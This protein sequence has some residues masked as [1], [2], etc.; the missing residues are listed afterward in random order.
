[1]AD[2]ENLQTAE[3]ET[4]QKTGQR[5]IF[6]DGTKAEDASCGLA[7]NRL[8]LWFPG[9]EMA[10]VAGVVFDPSATQRIIFEYGEMADVHDLFTVCT[11]LFIDGE[12]IVSACMVRKGG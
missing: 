11:N 1:M 4:E 8:W 7:E 5:L 9:W 3:P 6:A 12:G 2:Q 10:Q